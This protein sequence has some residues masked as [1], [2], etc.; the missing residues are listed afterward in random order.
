MRTINNPSQIPYIELSLVARQSV[1]ARALA[2]QKLNDRTLM[3]GDGNATGFTGEELIKAHVPALRQDPE[4]RNFDFFMEFKFSGGID[5]NGE[6]YL[7]SDVEPPSRFT[8]DVKSRR[9]KVPPRLS[10]DCKIPA[11]QV[12]RQKC[13]AYIFTAPHE[14]MAGGWLLGWA[15]KDHFR[16]KATLAKKGQ[17]HASG[18]T[19]K[20]DHYII[21]VAD[22]YPIADLVGTAQSFSTGTNTKDRS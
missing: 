16:A 11:Y 6:T 18:F 14:S 19:P 20:E 22:L 7:V 1:A 12:K 4:N 5:A 3:G 21:T 13:D 9:I 17:K 8:F 2:R 15:P 10:F